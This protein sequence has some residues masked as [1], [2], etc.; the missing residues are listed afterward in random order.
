[1]PSVLLT[2]AGCPS[3]RGAARRYPKGTE[4]S[5]SSKHPMGKPDLNGFCSTLG[6]SPKGGVEFESNCSRIPINKA[7]MRP[8]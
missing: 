3:R 6:N 1:M 7:K 4:Y 5:K 2:D 8:P